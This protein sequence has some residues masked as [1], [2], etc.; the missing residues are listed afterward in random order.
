M[1]CLFS[2]HDLIETESKT[3]KEI[4]NESLPS[5]YTE[6]ISEDEGREIIVN[7]KC[8]SCGKVYDNINECRKNLVFKHFTEPLQHFSRFCFRRRMERERSE[9]IG[10]IRKILNLQCLFGHDYETVKTMWE[11]HIE[12][13]EFG[14]IM[15]KQSSYTTVS[16]RIC[17]RCSH[18]DDGIEKYRRK[19]MRKY[20]GG[21]ER[22]KLAEEL[23]NSLSGNNKD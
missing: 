4:C 7:Y 3:K 15:S 19:V 5:R 10:R 17:L 23:Y 2:F 8:I 20:K 9:M 22:K 12:R 6:Y 21:K 1:K 16:T 14:Y 18:I 11:D 13:D